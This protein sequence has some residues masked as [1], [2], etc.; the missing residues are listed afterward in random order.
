MLR[1]QHCGQMPLQLPHSLQP[2]TGLVEQRWLQMRLWRAHHP[3][4]G[5]YANGISLSVGPSNDGQPPPR[6]DINVRRH[7]LCRSL[8]WLGGDNIAGCE[9]VNPLL[10]THTTYWAF[11]KYTRTVSDKNFMLAVRGNWARMS[12]LLPRRR[13]N[14]AVDWPL[15]ASRSRI[16]QE[17]AGCAKGQTLADTGLIAMPSRR[18]PKDVFPHRRLQCNGFYARAWVLAAGC[19]SRGRRPA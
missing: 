2:K 18:T 5:A 8:P 3:G 17:S 16:Q 19:P 13:G 7:L 6:P 15:G 11:N 10:P 9:S 4:T 1:G 14:T 12:G